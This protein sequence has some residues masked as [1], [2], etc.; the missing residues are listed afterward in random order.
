MRM[1]AQQRH[2]SRHH[3]HHAIMSKAPY[4]MRMS[5]Q[6]RHTSRHHGHH[7]HH[8]EGPLFDADVGTAGPDLAAGLAIP[9]EADDVLARR[10][11]R[12]P[13]QVLD[14]GVLADLLALVAERAGERR[15]SVAAGVVGS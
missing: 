6:Q 13:D 12:D 15:G 4:S 11:L 8:V 14:G 3:G 9:P 7:R 10:D 5:A 2:T 1:S